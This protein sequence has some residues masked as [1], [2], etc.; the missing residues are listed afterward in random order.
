VTRLEWLFWNCFLKHDETGY[1]FLRQKPVE[2]YILD[3]Y[4]AKLKLGVEI[5]GESHEWR[6][7]YDEERDMILRW[8]WIKIIRYSDTE[9]LKAFEWVRLDLEE[10]IKER[11][12]ELK[13]INPPS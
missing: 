10:K 9:V 13:V 7:D 4:C 6:S 3:F 5:D 12:E 11:A 1:R 8:L 2:W